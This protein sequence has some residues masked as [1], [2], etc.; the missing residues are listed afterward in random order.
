MNKLYV[1]SN[2][3]WGQ[4][5]GQMPQGLKE[6]EK[7]AKTLEISLEWKLASFFESEFV[8]VKND[9]LA[10]HFFTLEKSM[11][12]VLE[13]MQK[14]SENLLK[15]INTEI[16]FNDKKFEI[17]RE[18]ELK[19]L[20]D[21]SNQ[22][23]IIS[24][25]GGVGKTSLV[26]KIYESYEEDVPFYI[27]KAT[28]FEVRNINDIFGDFGLRDFLD[29]HK[30]KERKTIVIDSA[31]K[32]LDLKNTDPFKELLSAIVEDNWKV[33]FTT[34]DTYLKDLNYQF[35]EI[36]KI[37]PL[38]IGIGPLEQEELITISNRNA[39][40]LPKD[41][42]LLELIRNPF[43]L[44]EYLKFYKDIDEINYV[45]F[46]SELWE[47]RIKK[48]KPEREKCFLEIAAQRANTGQF[49]VDVTA[50]QGK[51]CDELMK[52]GMLGYEDVGYFITHDIYEEWA[53]E[54]IINKEFTNRS[55][56][57]GFFV[58]IGE[59]LPIRRCL[60]NWISEKLLLEDY[61]IVEFIEDT[62]KH[63]EIDS[64]WKDELFASILLS[65]YSRNFFDVFKN[66]LLSNDCRLLKRLT[67]I[68]RIACKEVDEELFKQLGIEDINL[69]T[70]EHILTKPKGV[71]WEAL[72]EF[73]FDNI[74]II[75]IENIN[76][77]LP[78]INDWNEKFRKGNTTR[79]A[80]LI[81]L[82]FYQDAIR[83]DPYYRRDEKLET[84]IK[85]IINGSYE[86]STE[87]KAII[88]EII[89]NKWKNHRDPYYDLAKFILTK[90]DGLPVCSV[91]PD[92]ILELADFYWTYTPKEN[93]LFSGWREDVEHDFGIEKDGI[94]YF[95]ASAYQSPIYWL[96]HIKPKATMD[97]IVNFTNKSVKKYI[98]SDLA[99]R[100]DTITE[101]EVKLSDGRQKKQYVSQC[102][103]EIYRGTSSPVSPNLLQSLHMALEKFLLELAENA[104]AE[105]LVS[106]LNYL[107]EISDSASISSV[108]TS[109]VLACPE[110]TFDI[111]KILFRTREFIIHD[112]HRSVS[113]QG[114]K[115]LYSIGQK[116]GSSKNNIYDIERLETCENKHRKWN[117]ESL[118]LNYQVFSTHESG[119]EEA[120]KRQEILWNI[121][122][123]YY[124]KLSPDSEQNEA[125]KTWR[126]FLARM[127]RRKMSIKAEETDE[128]ISIEFKPEI[129]PEID[130]F[131]EETQK[132]YK[133]HM[134]YV[135]LK[136]WA[137]F[138]S[139]NDDKYKEYE[140]YD[141]NPQNALEDVKEILEKLN[142]PYNPD[143]S[144]ETYA[145][146][147]LFHLFNNQI[148]SCVC[149]VL[150]EHYIDKLNDEEREFCKGIIIAK[151]ASC[152]QP[153]Y[154]YQVGDGVQ[155]AIAS[156]PKLMDLFP[157][158]RQTIKLLLLLILLKDES[159]GGIMSTERFNIFSMVAI[160][161]MW[162]KEFD[163]AHSLLLGYLVLKPKYNELVD[164]SREKS[165]EDGLNGFDLGELLDRFLID[166][167]MNL[168]KMFDNEFSIS[169]LG[170]IQELELF[171][172]S[173][174]LKMMP[175]KLHF[176]EHIAIAHEIISKFAREL[177]KGRDGDNV[178]YMVRDEFLERY[179]YLVLNSEIKEVPQL[180]QPFIDN[181]NSTE[182]IAEMFQ[183]FIYAEDRMHSYDNFWFV[184]NHFKD[185]MV[186]LTNNGWYVDKIIKSYLFA[187]THW[188]DSKK[189]WD[190]LKVINMRLIKDVSEHMGQHPSVLYSI[191]KL[192]NDIGSSF[193]ADGLIWVSNML[194]RHSEYYT[195]KLEMNTSYYLENLVRRY[196]YEERE[197]IKKNKRLK[198]KI[199]VVLNFLIE[200]GSSVS[201]I[202]RENII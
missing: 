194:S 157:K 69:F 120:K 200:K 22:V 202:L 118:C 9:N 168:N 101:V 198:Q 81:A 131:R 19:L 140:R 160:H 40:T 88:T 127:D 100:L 98:Y 39:F 170:N 181:F 34:R 171:I 7:L 54:K 154:V 1:Y 133:E 159:V 33:I 169:D 82:K 141:S 126:L 173:N 153:N 57:H 18:T 201:Y 107:L 197:K 2:Q 176:K 111:A 51:Q 185:K 45:E 21:G 61:E 162:E 178:E 26:K 195:S 104:D 90:L 36:Y 24:G 60:R 139:K 79:F 14:H 136:L 23:C 149:A 123:D 84:I 89:S 74:E 151:V 190:S 121:L 87:L 55:D 71:G 97:F 180:I 99:S 184:W 145:E 65:N 138:K 42:K 43:Y 8:T 156:L 147:E 137:D 183:K 165:F 148:P 175:T 49:F 68:L 5:K 95:P 113:E 189:E 47:Q 58:S 182:P 73:A 30:D 122:N 56:E 102:L 28:E 91:V 15:Y 116:M 85:T 29:V 93:R 27:F 117:L 108:V 155:E 192:L 164:E 110:K 94:E 146:N 130:A 66:E 32:L 129:D 150:V 12:S 4:N 72:I 76:F 166:N 83:R 112:T 106:W 161:K 163:N 41:K 48:S 96:L 125:D 11:F 152:V 44:N 25:A 109:V 144:Q 10:K 119:E 13:D 20:I 177:T 16:S 172:L 199:L 196:V 86:L 50:E 179:A 17:K 187:Q 63:N 132:V 67:F 128:G 167:E 103:W 70:L 80:G 105:V 142:E 92:E 124:S 174:A 134:R 186:E 114:A 143:L 52:D 193:Y 64:F 6:I 158:E 53:L 37:V 59:S 38:N 135:P 78:I 188:N 75:G 35:F 115:T 77:V 62:I 46:K 3:E 31:E 191:S